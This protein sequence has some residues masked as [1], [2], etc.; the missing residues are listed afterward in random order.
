[1]PGWSL[2]W[3]GAVTKP[4]GVA[5]AA[6]STFTRKPS[7][8]EARKK[9]EKR[10]LGVK[11]GRIVR[12]TASPAFSR[13]SGTP[14]R[15]RATEF[16]P[17]P[18]IE[19]EEGNVP[20]SPKPKHEEVYD[21]AASDGA[22]STYA[23]RHSTLSGSAS[24]DRETSPTSTADTHMSS[25]DED[26]FEL[27]AE[28]KRETTDTGIIEAGPHIDRN[29]PANADWTTEEMDLFDRLQDCGAEPMLPLSWKLDFPILPDACFTSDASAALICPQNGTD[30]HASRALKELLEVGSRIRLRNET[31][32]P[33]TEVLCREIGRY[34]KWAAK[35][36]GMLRTD[37][38]PFL[39]VRGGWD[40]ESAEHIEGRI[41]HFMQNE[42]RNKHFPANAQGPH[43]VVWCIV[44][45]QG[46]MTFMSLD[47][48]RPDA[49]A[50]PLANF[51]W[52]KPGQDVWQ[53][54]AVALLAMMQRRILQQMTP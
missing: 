13:T 23:S 48:S 6:Q 22:D 5:G 11:E 21:S 42:M 53:A 49:T 1:M 52:N 24:A 32:K 51:D 28:E 37:F 43:P 36:V 30:H 35:D 2:G 10:A 7:E 12:S 54:M 34:L 50:K 8:D 14:G 9:L 31:G 25:D 26:P 27:S 44:V 47:T 39:A 29:D 4:V 41:Q 38:D 16:V 15:G 45:V 40:S 17:I 33:T 19:Q 20:E 46:T 3:F 18:S